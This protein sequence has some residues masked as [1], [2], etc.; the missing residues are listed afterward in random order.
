MH[1]DVELIGFLEDDLAAPDRERVAEHLE[2]CGLCRET[3]AD[4]RELLTALGRSM[5]EPPDVDWGR[6]RTE[7][8]AKLVERERRWSILV[9]ARSWL[10]PLPLTLTA[11][12]AGI[13]V[14]LHV[15]DW[16]RPQ[17]PDL[18]A[19]EQTVIGDRLEL[20]RHYDL[21]ERL[22]LLEDLDVIRELDRGR[23]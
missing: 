5:P 1:P 20:L 12:A 14:V 16:N 13:L 2:N 10:R 19:L 7:L 9:T 23:Q 8:R 17:P 3:A 21:V 6:Y 22:E 15:G 18:V 4:F 11:A